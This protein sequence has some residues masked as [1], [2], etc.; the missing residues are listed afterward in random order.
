MKH[1]VHL[2]KSQK[3]LVPVFHPLFKARV[4]KDSL[5]ILVKRFLEEGGEAN[6]Q[7]VVLKCLPLLRYTVGRFLRNWPIT[8][9]FVDD[10]V[11]EGALSICQVVNRLEEKH[12][13]R[14]SSYI[15]GT[16]RKSIELHINDL[17]SLAAPRLKK[18]YEERKKNGK[19]IYLV[20]T[21]NNTSNV[22]TFNFDIELLEAF[23]ILE[24]IILT[25][26]EKEYFE[27]LLNG[28]MKTEKG[29]KRLQERFEKFLRS[30]ADD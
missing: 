15:L 3:G 16:I 22:A 2:R 25:P 30:L 27:S 26:D 24:K 28:G 19:P 7:E 4:P 21:S 18:N 13:D 11:G 6:K 20:Q 8:K 29:K 14:L 5:E 12:L 17:K 10:I 9:S 1:I 23:E